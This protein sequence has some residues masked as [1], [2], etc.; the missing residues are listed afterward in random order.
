IENIT[1]IKDASS[2]YGTKGANGAIIITTIHAKDL[3]TKIDF[4]AYTGINSAP[5][6]L[7][8]MKSGDY[9]NFLSDVLKSRG[10]T[11]AQIQAQ[12]YMNDN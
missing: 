11:D 8:V 1:V 5:E 9:R 7:P 12:P 10:W 6:N 4:A 3:A 2:T